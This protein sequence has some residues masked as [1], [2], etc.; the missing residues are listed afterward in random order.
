MDL[1]LFQNMILMEDNNLHEKTYPISKDIIDT[2]IFEKISLLNESGDISNINIIPDIEVL[3][4]IPILYEGGV[5]GTNNISTHVDKFDN[6]FLL[7]NE[8]ETYSIICY[9]KVTESHVLLPIIGEGNQIDDN[10]NFLLNK[11]VDIE[12]IEILPTF[13]SG[14]VDNNLST[15]AESFNITEDGTMH[16]SFDNRS[17]MSQYDE[18]KE[19][20]KSNLE[21]R[22]FDAIKYDLCHLFYLINKLEDIYRT[23]PKN[24]D[25]QDVE[26]ARAFSKNTFKATMKVVQ[27]EDPDFNFLEFY[28]D[29][30]IKED[31]ITITTANITGL[32]KLLLAITT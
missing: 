27:T 8:G 22:N 18:I 14:E 16:I 26:K 17:Y 15:L 25:M 28:K 30:N 4:D 12:F 20:I 5:Y 23:K 6:K 3:E 7:F 21:S 24:I 11:D 2:D 9:N 13:S 10:Y 19:S 1:E 31:D 29:L 32:K